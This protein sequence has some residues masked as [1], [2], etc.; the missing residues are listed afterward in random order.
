MYRV[1]RSIMDENVFLFLMYRPSCL[2]EA[3]GGLEKY[4]F[5]WAG[6][7]AIHLFNLSFIFLSNC[8]PVAAK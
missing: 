5:V 3:Y 1:G 2:T 7:L 4:W 8:I 6:L